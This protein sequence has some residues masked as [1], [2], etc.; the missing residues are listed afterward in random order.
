MGEWRLGGIGAK[1]SNGSNR[2]VP[3]PRPLHVLLALAR[4]LILTFCFVQRLP[5]DGVQ[6]DLGPARGQ[7]VQ[8]RCARH[9]WWV[10][11]SGPAGGDDGC[12]REPGMLVKK[13]LCSLPR[14]CHF[15]PPPP[16]RLPS[17]THMA[18]PRPSRY[19]PVPAVDRT[20]Q[21]M[22]RLSNGELPKKP[23]KVIALVTGTD[24]LGFAFLTNGEP[25]IVK[26]VD[27]LVMRWV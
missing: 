24:D 7:Q 8:G 2:V 19:L 11:A 12:M 10:T 4:P 16:P 17:H 23:P 20:Y 14:T 1:Q 25:A 9:L 5:C 3:D 21:L 15:T 22:W 13:V 26:E 6:R 18:Q 27:P